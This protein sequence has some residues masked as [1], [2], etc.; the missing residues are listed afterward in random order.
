MRNALLQSGIAEGAEEAI[1]I[2][3]PFA[4]HGGKDW[5]SLKNSPEEESGK[6]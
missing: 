3:A 5:S 1:A 2:P 6:F 4:F